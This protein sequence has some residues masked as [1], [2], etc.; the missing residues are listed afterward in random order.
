MSIPE[1]QQ[2]PLPPYQQ[3]VDAVIAA[4][5]TDARR[6][7]SET[8]AQARLER[9][10]RNE[11]TAEEPVP[12]WR[13]FLAQF[14]DVLVI[15]LL[16]ATAISAVLWLIERESALPYEAIAIFAVV[17]LNAIMGYIQE[18]RAESAVAALRQM[19]AAQANVHARRR[20][21]KRSG[22]GDR[23]RR[24]HPHRRR[25]HHSR[26]RAPDSVH[27]AANGRSGADRRKPAG[28]E[29]HR[30]RGR[31]SRTRRPQQHDLQRHGGDVRARQSRGHGDRNANRNGAHRRNAERSS[32]AKPRRCKRNSTA[33][34][35]CSAS[36]SS[37]S[38]W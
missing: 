2:D 3:P 27:R 32:R 13:K 30:S 18:S 26:R 15:L 19:A 34:A 38:P 36:S 12:A 22:G 14:K 31:R 1:I 8:E 35:S 25:R 7:L 29:G 21:A 17:L 20:A 28:V 11:L 5:G 6:G 9:H 37:S 24:P 10:G 23:A 16:I 4:L 33:S